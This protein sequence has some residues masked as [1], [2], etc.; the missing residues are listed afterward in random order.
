MLREPIEICRLTHRGN[1][2]DDAN[3]LIKDSLSGDVAFIDGITTGDG[4]E[5]V[6]W[7]ILTAR[8]PL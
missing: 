5:S 4:L 8:P 1:I 3:E 7:P 2:L 6:I